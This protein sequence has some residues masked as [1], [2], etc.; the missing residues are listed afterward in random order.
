MEERARP[1]RPDPV[2]PLGF[3]EGSEVNQRGL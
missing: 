3:A 2:G 1:H